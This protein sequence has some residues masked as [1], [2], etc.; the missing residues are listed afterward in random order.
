[1]EGGE[2]GGYGRRAEGGREGERGKRGEH[3]CFGERGVWEEGQEEEVLRILPDV[4]NEFRV[5]NIRE[6]VS[7]S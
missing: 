7:F 4:W 5:Y 2:K 1:M 6:K 3:V